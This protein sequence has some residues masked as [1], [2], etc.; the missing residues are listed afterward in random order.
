VRHRLVGLGV[1]HG[2]Q[3]PRVAGALCQRF[4]EAQVVTDARS[5]LVERGG[6]RWIVPE[7][8]RRYLLVE[9][10][11]AGTFS[12]EVKDAPGARLYGQRHR[13]RVQQ[14]RSFAEYSTMQ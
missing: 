12:V 7:I 3:L 14:A 10:D 13:W 1:E 4:P 11:Q 6:A 5:F 9:L 8:G 2:C